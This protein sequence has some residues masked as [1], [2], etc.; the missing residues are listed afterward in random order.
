MR[1]MAHLIGSFVG[2]SLK[3]EA[4]ASKK[5]DFLH[6]LLA[7]ALGVS[8]LLAQGLASPMAQAGTTIELTNADITFDGVQG[9]DNAGWSV[10]KGDVNGDGFED[11]IIGAPNADPGGRSSAGQSYVVFGSATLT[12]TIEL[13]PDADITINGINSSDECGESV[14][15]GDFNG[16]GVD[17]VIIGAEKADPG[18]RT[19]AG[20]TYVVFGSPTLTGAIEL[21]TDADITINGIDTF[22]SSG[23]S[24]S[25]GDVNGDGMDDIIIGA[26]DAAGGQ[27]YV[28]FGSATL[29]DAI[30]LSTGADIT[31]NG[32]GRAGWSVSAGDINGDGFDD[33]IIGALDAN[34]GGRSSA[35]QSY[36]VFGSA[37]LSGTIELSTGA[38]IIM[39]GINFVDQSGESVSS[40]D[41]N[42]DGF[43]DI[44][45]G[46]LNADPGSRSSAGQSY[47]VLGSAT[48][49][50]TIELAT[51]SD[52]TINGINNFDFSG[53]SVASG[54]VNGDG[55]YDII[56]GAN[57]SDPGGRSSA[58]QSYVVFGSAILSGTIEL[59]TGA[60]ITMNGIHIGDNAGWSAAAGDVNGDG[61]DDVIIGAH[62]ATFDSRSFAGQGYVLFGFV[63]VPPVSVTTIPD[64]H[65]VTQGGSLGF[66]VTFTNNTDSTQNFDFWTNITLPNGVVFPFNRELLGP[67]LVSLGPGE[68]RTR[69]ISY[70]IPLGAYP[71][72]YTH[73]AYVGLHPDIWDQSDFQFG[74]APASP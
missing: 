64:I 18:G 25:S 5:R 54:D 32:I 45:I 50:G 49:S 48:L 7:I 33:I 20:Q 13:S 40:G 23:A 59:S 15:A 55:F 3:K 29:S 71:V 35:G 39:N 43:E 37:T 27:S 14:T 12:G 8:I 34:P 1:E 47:V 4:Q 62:L 17:D 6:L 68:S 52:I 2:S 60:D 72:I 70:P 53:Q 65:I 22:D 74:I 24:V 16:D 30:E 11:I 31:M 41:V 73:H 63:P 38:D 58:G 51:G 21:A 67:L 44:I 46:A 9:G 69:H 19:D 61:A 36:V 57:L 66:Q 42:G 26:P 56:I 10:A 28:V